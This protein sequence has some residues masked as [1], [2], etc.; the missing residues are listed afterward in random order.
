MY[1]THLVRLLDVRILPVPASTRTWPSSP[2][3]KC[4]NKHSKMFRAKHPS[5]PRAHSTAVDRWCFAVNKERNQTE[6]INLID[7]T[8]RTS[9][10]PLIELTCLQ[11]R[12][13]QYK[14]GMK[15]T[16]CS[17]TISTACTAVITTSTTFTLTELCATILASIFARPLRSG[18]YSAV[19][20]L[21]PWYANPG[22]GLKT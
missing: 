22:Q 1:C 12:P 13:K 5:S 4:K 3:T 7:T 8:H 19:R 11:S 10:P 2:S 6:N 16:T 20:E 9:P 18:Y 21:F 15:Q 17:T 14:I